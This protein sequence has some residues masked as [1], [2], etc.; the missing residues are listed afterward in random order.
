MAAWHEKRDHEPQI[1]TKFQITKTLL[2][3]P[4][5]NLDKTSSNKQ[6]HIRK[7]IQ[8]P[9]RSVDSEAIHQGPNPAKHTSMSHERRCDLCSTQQCKD[10]RTGNDLCKNMSRIYNN[11][12]VARLMRMYCDSYI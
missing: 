6:K 2:P 8:A 11:M 1:P 12:R 9:G 3:N 10:L 5:S 7:T 4:D